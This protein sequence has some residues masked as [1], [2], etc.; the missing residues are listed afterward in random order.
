MVR[1]RR[2]G[3]KKKKEGKEEGKRREGR[4]GKEKEEVFFKRD[5]RKK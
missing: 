4:C 1:E 2:K 3:E 5:R